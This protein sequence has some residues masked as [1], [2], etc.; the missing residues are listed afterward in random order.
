MV[1]APCAVP[2]RRRR[3][4]LRGRRGP[5]F[6]RRHRR[7]ERY[8]GSRELGFEERGRLVEERAGKGRGG[9]REDRF[10]V[11]H[12]VC[13]VRKLLQP[14][15]RPKK[16]RTDLHSRR[17]SRPTRT[18]RR[19]H[20][21]LRVRSRAARPFP[22]SDCALRVRRQPCPSSGMSAAVQ[23]RRRQASWAIIRR[24]QDSPRREQRPCKTRC[25]DSRV[26]PC[27]AAASQSQVGVSLGE[28]APPA[29]ARRTCKQRS[30]A[31]KWKLRRVGRDRGYRGLQCESRVHSTTGCRPLSP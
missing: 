1:E 3:I 13:H 24:A 16:L 30:R 21:L 15:V 2:C 19:S 5:P 18:H 12:C 26:L 17:Q 14:C 27:T 8:Q 28:E 20:P 31:G 29:L 7:T 10:R 6:A 23:A 9:S 4:L 25:K 11:A 22:S